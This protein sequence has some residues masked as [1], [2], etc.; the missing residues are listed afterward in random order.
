MALA[1]SFGFSHACV[2]VV[3]SFDKHIKWTLIYS[4]R[5]KRKVTNEIRELL[6]SVAKCWIAPRI[7]EFQDIGSRDEKQFPCAT[8]AD[9]LFKTNFKINTHFHVRTSI[10]PYGLLTYSGKIKWDV[11]N[12]Q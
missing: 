5:G 4:R 7:S 10:L 9:C 2:H 11:V 12:S 6:I 8:Q 1:E 3:T